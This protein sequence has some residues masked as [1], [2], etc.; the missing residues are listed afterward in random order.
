MD[1][2]LEADIA[3]AVA[4]V[5]E[6]PR[7]VRS[8]IDQGIMAGRDHQRRWQSGEVLRQQGRGPPVEVVPRIVDVVVVVVGESLVGQQVTLAIAGVRGMLA[9]QSV[10]G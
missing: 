6:T 4:G 3:H 1:L 9:T 5:G 10:A 8:L 7:V 2:S